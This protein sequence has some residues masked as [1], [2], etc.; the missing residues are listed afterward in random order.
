VKS[1]WLPG[2]VL[3]IGMGGFVDG[4]VFHQLLQ[5]HGML[6]GKHPKTD[7][8]NFEV[9]MFWDGLFHLCT[10]LATAAGIA[11]LFRAG[12]EHAVAWSGRVLLGGML[13]GWGA[14]NLVEGVLDHHVL[15]LHHVVERLG[16]SIYDGL[17]LLSGA[18]LL[19]TGWGLARDR[20]TV[21]RT[22]S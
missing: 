7:L 16:P 21:P 4:I 5:T 10:W 13:A 14:F 2:F 9:N 12:R 1:L 17:F 15:H 18:A 3:G 22:T 6:T 11:L 8:V 20:A 19:A